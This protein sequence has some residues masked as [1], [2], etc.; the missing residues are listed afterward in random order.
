[1]GISES[2][3][4]SLE[5]GHRGVLACDIDTRIFELTEKQALSWLYAVA[6]PPGLEPRMP[7]PKSGVLPITPWRITALT[8]VPQP[9]G[10][11]A[12]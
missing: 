4:E 7:E 9:A 6:P 10:T 5:P 1:M 8:I 11:H 2:L 3:G 12:R